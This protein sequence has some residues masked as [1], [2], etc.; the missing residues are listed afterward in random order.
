MYVP[1]YHLEVPLCCPTLSFH[2]STLKP[3]VLN[4]SF[5]Y[6]GCTFATLLPDGDFAH[7]SCA[8]IRCCIFAAEA[9]EFE[10]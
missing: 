10:G 4:Q 7:F 3:A 2:A 8:R 6:R 5:A 1:S 9:I